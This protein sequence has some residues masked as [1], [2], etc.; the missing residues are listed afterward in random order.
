MELD[1]NYKNKLREE[2]REIRGW[3]VKRD[4]KMSSLEPFSTEWLQLHKA[5][6][7]ALQRRERNLY[8]LGERDVSLPQQ[9]RRVVP[10]ESTEVKNP[11]I[12]ERFREFVDNIQK[13][14]ILP[15]TAW[16]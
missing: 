1:S 11:T 13:A 8:I 9:D 16:R 4:K 14:H 6:K 15:I 7:R 2:N 3:M 12:Q 10:A 5:N